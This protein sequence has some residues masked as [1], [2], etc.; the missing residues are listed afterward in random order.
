[1]DALARHVGPVVYE[2]SVEDLRGTALSD[3]T[4]ETIAVDLDP[5]ERSI[6]RAT[7]G[8]FAAYYSAKQ[9]ELPG[10][11][12]RELVR[13]AQ[14]SE[15][16]REAL[17]AWRA[18]RAL[19]AYPTGKRAALRALIEKHASDRVL[20][21]T[22]DNTTAYAIARELLVMPITCDIGRK[23]RADM[24]ERFQTGES[25]VLVSAQVLDEGF[26]VPDAEVAILVGGTASQRRQVQRIG[27]VLRPRPG[28]HAMV[29]ELVVRAT[30]EVRQV[31]ARRGVTQTGLARSLEAWS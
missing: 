17:T 7:R 10:I 27:R 20:V 16:G 14:R 4:H 31:A 12:W 23:E 3:F 25:S 13:T 24:L 6:Y 22:A 29:Y 9:Y 1:M 18:S 2:L 28:K 15:I 11:G 8:V 30:S 19:L 26:D 21:F 5:D